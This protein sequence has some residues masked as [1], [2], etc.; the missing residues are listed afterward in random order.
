MAT[1]NP[2]RVTYPASATGA[3]D[4]LS[5]DWRDGIPA[6]Y[7]YEVQF[8]VGASGSVT[9]ESTLDDTNDASITPG[10]MAETSAIT[11]DT[12]GV[13]A[14][15]VTAVR[16][17][18]SSLSGGTL[19]LKLLGGA[20]IGDGSGT[21]AS[22]GGGV[23]SAV[24]I[25]DGADV[26]LG[27]TTDDA[28][29][30]TEPYTAMSALRAIAN[31]AISALASPV[32]LTQAGGEALAADDAA[33]GTTYPIPMGGIY[34]TTLPTYTNLDRG[35]AQLD[36]NGNLRA[37]MVVTNQ[38]GAD[39]K[40]NLEGGLLTTNGQASFRSLS[41]FPSA[42]NGSTWDRIRMNPA[43]SGGAQLMELGPYSRG[44]VTADGQI[45][46]SAGFI[47]TISIAPLTATPT[48]GLLTI[49]D[50]TTE[51]GTVVYAE[52]IFATTPGHTV[53]LDIPC[54]T[55]IYVGFDGTLAN[56]QVTVAYR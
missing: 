15:P 13:I 20:I 18:I 22:G 56:V 40:S 10:W 5:V 29:T 16:V 25:A 53:T 11:A 35:Q 6:G 46:A 21:S 37:A 4:A 41:V 30:G 44:R 19:T 55:G 24:T 31:A 36:V 27:S 26:A 1:S 38:T 12:R 28:Y 2:I 3:Q 34:R 45:K 9:I 42:F 8:D 33:A 50:S 7:S 43:A 48:A 49:Y 23:A 52:W 32:N 39:G 17:N 14:H 47:H 54:A 51:T